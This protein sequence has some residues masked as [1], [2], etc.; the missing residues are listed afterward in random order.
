MC[1]GCVCSGCTYIH[2]CTC[3][4]VNAHVL[5]AFVSSSELDPFGPKPDV[6]GASDI[7]QLLALS[8]TV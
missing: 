6:V 2:V 5:W 1:V 8:V 7:N 4:S 3:A